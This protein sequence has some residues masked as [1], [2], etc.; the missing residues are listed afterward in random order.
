MYKHKYQWLNLPFSTYF[1]L[2]DCDK[3]MD[4]V[5]NYSDSEGLTILILFFQ[6]SYCEINFLKQQ[7]ELFIYGRR[8]L[9]FQILLIKYYNIEQLDR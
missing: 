6:L 9:F 3:N 4:F 5:Q 8:F 2:F 1:I 7:T